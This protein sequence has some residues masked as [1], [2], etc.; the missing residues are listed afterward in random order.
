MRK[1]FLALLVCAGIYANAN[2]AVHAGH[3]ESLP[4][5]FIPLREAV[6]EQQLTANQITPLF[7]QVSGRARVE[8]SGAD[9][10]VMLSR[11][12][13]M[14]GRAFHFEERN[15]EAVNHYSE[16][17]QFAERALAIQP[18]SEAWQMLAEN[19]SQL[20]SARSSTTFAMA[21]GLRVE[22]Y[23]RNALAL[24]SRNA[25]AQ[26]MIAARW[27][28]APSPFNNL[29]RGLTMMR[30]ILTEGDMYKD[31]RFNVYSAIG[32]AYI[33]LRRPADARPWLEM[34]LQVYPTNQFAQSLLARL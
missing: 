1:F 2:T 5:W 15:R 12:E 30:D 8:L 7:L 22:R 13:Y 3:T 14:M 26:Y 29:R 6:Y 21:N 25:A 20:I 32:F 28:F 16:G 31:D 27:I 9:L 33:Q 11:A 24:N 4:Y 23:A 10:Y 17:M 18:S 19:L 34:A